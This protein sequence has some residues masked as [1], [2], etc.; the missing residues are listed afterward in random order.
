[1]CQDIRCVGIRRFWSRI[2]FLP[3]VGLVTE[4]RLY[5]EPAASFPFGN[6]GLHEYCEHQLRRERCWWVGVIV[7]KRCRSHQ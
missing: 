6:S 2:A 5:L 7:V 4:R 1:M 3:Y